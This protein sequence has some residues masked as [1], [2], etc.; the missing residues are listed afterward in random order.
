M[1]R[2]AYWIHWQYIH[3]LKLQCI[4]SRSTP[5]HLDAILHEKM[6]FAIKFQLPWFFSSSEYKNPK[7]CTASVLWGRIAQEPNLD[8]IVRIPLEFVESTAW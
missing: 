5:Q 6:G 2:R 8:I 7:Y 3:E 4:Q 1:E